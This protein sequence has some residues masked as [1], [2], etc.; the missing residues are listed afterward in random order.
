MNSVSQGQ[1]ETNPPVELIREIGE[2][3]ASGALR[4][5]RARAKA[6]IYFENGAIVF[7]AS[8]LRPHQ[9]LE[10][11]KRTQFLPHDQTATL[12]ANAKDEE[13]LD[14]LSTRDKLKPET[15]AGIRANHVAD[16]LRTALLWTDGEWSFDPR[17]R[18]AGGTRVPVDGKRLLLESARHLPATYI[19][20]RF[21]DMSETFV[22]TTNGTPSNLLPSEAFVLSRVTD[23]TT[24]TELL[25]LCGLSE[26]EALRTIY[27][28]SI[29][30][31][32]SRNAWPLANIAG[33]DKPSST[34]SSA[35]EETDEDDVEKLF[36]RLTAASD[37]YEVLGIGRHAAGDEVK[38]A[39]HALA[40]RYHPDRFHQADPQ[41]RNR[42]DSAFARISRAYE[43]LNDATSRAAYDAQF[44]SGSAALGSAPQA[45]K[46]KSRNAKPDN[47][48]AEASFQRGLAALNENRP[49]HALRFF[50]E[51]A[52]L[53]PRRAQYRAEY[54]RA[55]TRDQKTRRL[56]EFE[57]KA[58]T[59]LEP[60]NATYRV[61]LAELYIALGLRRRAQS[62][63][64]KALS[65]DPKNVAARALLANSN[66]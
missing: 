22:P 61:L 24:L 47:D 27:G 43:T 54:G 51:A 35:T 64:Q 12:P 49:E 3:R 29:A 5:S 2:K 11:L 48:R 55:L 7:A 17:V 44:A 57:L 16:I 34:E 30:G 40:R 45:A 58:A 66:R 33:S 1:L 32:L 50:A 53:E 46:D 28:L 39:Y 4:L 19:R 31:Y 65:I 23:A 10:F 62:E 38:N 25:A 15:I 59:S 6:A 9:L 26:P 37:H 18:M 42:V 13:L 21:G 63:V 60:D 8:N 52:S 56:A 36:A 14:L 41:L 20:G